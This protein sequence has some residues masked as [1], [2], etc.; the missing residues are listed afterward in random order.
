MD[1]VLKHDVC[2]T[3]EQ[4]GRNSVAR[5][6]TGYGLDDQG[7][8]VRVPVDHVIKTGSGV[9]PMSTGASFHGGKVAGA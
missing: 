5:I 9:H 2:Y 3:W 8:G 4:R 1:N 7:V 6:A